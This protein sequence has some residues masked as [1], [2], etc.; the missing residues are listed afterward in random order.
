M[1]VQLNPQIPIWHEKHGEGYAIGW[2]DF[3]QDH[4]MLWICAFSKTGQ[5]WEI[6]NPEI[7]LQWNISM[8][9]TPS[10]KGKDL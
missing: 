9:R 5:V 8:Q 3:S 10:D 6:P 1:I 2:K 7:R 4:H